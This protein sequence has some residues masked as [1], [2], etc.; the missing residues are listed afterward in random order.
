MAYINIAPQ[1][2]YPFISGLTSGS[3]AARTVYYL[4]T[5]QISLRQEMA[6]NDYSADRIYHSAQRLFGR[7]TPLL[8]NSSNSVFNA[9]ATASSNPMVVTATAANGAPLATLN[10]QVVKTATSQAILSDAKASYDYTVL[11]RSTF[12]FAIDRGLKTDT[13]K[14]EISGFD[15]N[16]EIMQKVADAINQADAGISAG[17]ID[18]TQARTSRLEI[19]GV[20]RSDMTTVTVRDLSGDLMRQLG[21]STGQNATD[22]T[23]GLDSTGG[24]A[25]FTVNGKTFYSGTN[26]ANI[27]DGSLTFNFKQYDRFATAEDIYGEWYDN[28]KQF[29]ERAIQT[30][31]TGAGVRPLGDYHETFNLEGTNSNTATVEVKPDTGRITGAVADFMHAFNQTLAALRTDTAYGYRSAGGYLGGVMRIHQL[32]LAE[33][34]VEKQG[35]GYTVDFKQLAYRLENKFEETKDLFGGPGGVAQKTVYGVRKILNAP[36]SGLS[37]LEAA[38]GKFSTLNFSGLM[39]DQN[40]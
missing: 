38:G 5:Q 33:A 35:G 1:T 24:E 16:K 12:Q 32:D 29:H 30:A 28:G 37:N 2:F 23:G 39:T 3:A 31:D 6:L 21:V 14:V 26:I 10:V 27:F 13:F 36:M 7:T 18:N 4:G 22:A 11:D 17:V 15:S 19:Q 40:A 20:D 25:V 34:G 9:R 8:S